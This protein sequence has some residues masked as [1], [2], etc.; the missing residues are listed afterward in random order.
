MS[1]LGFAALI[2]VGTLLLMLPAASTTQALAFVDALFTA[3]SASCVTGLVVVDTG[4]AL[5]RFGQIVVLTLIQI[6]GLGI[7]TISTLFLLIAGRRPSLA[8]RMVITDTFT[9]SGERNIRSLLRD[10]IIFTFAIE[11]IGGALLFAG[12]F[13]GRDPTDALYLALFHSISAFC[14]AGFALFGD[15]FVG[16]RHSLILNLTLC[17]LIV[18]GGIGFLVLSE[19]KR[20]FP[21]HK[22][23]W[24]RLSL[25]TKM[26]LSA[27]AL[28]LGFSTLMVLVMEWDN[29]LAQLSVPQRVLAAF[30]QAVTTRTAGFNTLPIADL[31]N[32][33]LFVFILLMFVGAS[34]GSCGG[35][36]KTSTLAALV[37]MGIA[38]LRGHLRPHVF[39]RTISETS[40]G[41]AISVVMIS[42]LVVV[43][44]TMAILISELGETPHPLSRGKFLELLFETVSA[45]GT[46]GLSTGVT[47]GLSAVGKFIIT[48]MMFV[49]RLGPMMIALAV[50]R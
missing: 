44:G 22:R 36:I 37:L 43:L 27:T 29:T 6:G 46:V 45:F 50:S 41:K 19:L 9:H 28:L 12:F 42:V 8:E 20:Q 35:G 11:A 26:V 17:F 5:S 31:A 14:N 32:E 1:V 16:F 34:P 48:G 7:M 25:H 24:K 38:R 33:T 39:Q 30:F 13:P 4:Q 3:T 18:S 23:T 21:F 2:A 10:V 47:A 15:S 40:A 49:G